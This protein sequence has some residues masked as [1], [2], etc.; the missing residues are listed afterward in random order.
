MAVP[1]LIKNKYKEK[2]FYSI[3]S[4]YLVNICNPVL[5]GVIS[6]MYIMIGVFFI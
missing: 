6:A 4:D 3:E 1:T 5:S 2:H